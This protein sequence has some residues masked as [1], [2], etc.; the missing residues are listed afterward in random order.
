[1]PHRADVD[2]FAG[3]LYRSRTS[4]SAVRSLLGYLAVFAVLTHRWWSTATYAVVPGCDPRDNRLVVWILGWVTQALAHAPTK[5]FDAPIFFPAPTQLAG[6]EHLLSSQLVFAPVYWAT[7]NAVLGANVVALLSYPASAFAMERL[8]TAQRLTPAA[9]WFGGLAFALGILRAPAS[10]EVL[11]FL[12]LFLPLVALRIQRLR[13]HPGGREFGLLSVCLLLAMFSSYYLTLLVVLTTAI[14]G[15]FEL[16][17]CS[18]HRTR[19]VALI[20]TSLLCASLILAA[21]SRPYVGRLMALAGRPGSVQIADSPVG[22]TPALGTFWRIAARKAFANYTR[23][24]VWLVLVALAIGGG[25][26]G[27]RGSGRTLMAT[28]TVFV[29]AG[30]ALFTFGWPW[31]DRWVK[32]FRDQSRYLLLSSFGFSILIAQGFDALRSK[33]PQRGGGAILLLALGGSLVGTR[34]VA[35]ASDAVLAVSRDREHYRRVAALVREQGPGP[36]LEIPYVSNLLV[37]RAPEQMVGQLEHG[38]PLINGYSGYRP[39][40][41]RLIASLIGALPSRSALDDLVDITHLRWIVVRPADEWPDPSSRD[42]FLAGLDRKPA[43]GPSW[44]IDGWVVQRLDRKP[45]HRRWFDAVAAGPQPGRSV[46]GT[47][48]AP[49]PEPEAIASVSARVGP[50]RVLSGWFLGAQATARNRGAA[51]WPTWAAGGSTAPG[52]V[53][54]EVR[55]R[56]AG[57]TSADWGPAQV[58][59][60]RRDVLPTETLGQPLVV[61]TPAEPGAYDLRIALKQND[62]ATF[63]APGNEMAI[64]RLDV[65]R[66][67]S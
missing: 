28:S 60:L 45:K 26:A 63:S 3:G 4:R 10:L 39:E 13:E 36:M 33:L 55:W 51:T 22:T 14:W 21:A 50:G 58:L 35:P 25:I 49:I 19:I 23:D 47:S 2:A 6:S 32:F 57:G 15:A 12:T 64:L 1:M 18:A 34:S 38:M 11:Q 43:L 52:L 27:L 61:R 53:G 41:L 30:V 42:W 66:R 7:G 62:G 56:R 17:R 9:A 8:L 59:P 31:L 48:L 54:W 65:V 5:L 44:T 20:G 67:E 46:L 16:T 37:D 24:P 29:V 40:H